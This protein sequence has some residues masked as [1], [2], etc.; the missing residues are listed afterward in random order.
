MLSAFRFKRVISIAFNVQCTIPESWC[1][2]HTRW[3]SAL[4]RSCT[5]ICAHLSSKRYLHLQTLITIELDFVRASAIIHSE[6]DWIMAI[7]TASDLTTRRQVSEFC[8]C[9]ERTPLSHLSYASISIKPKL[10]L[11]FSDIGITYFICCILSDS[12]GD[13]S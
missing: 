13:C 4:S 12:W 2:H 9:S 6:L 3:I 1:H 11:Y 10:R 7:I 5:L 8:S